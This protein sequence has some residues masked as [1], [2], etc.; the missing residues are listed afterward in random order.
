MGQVSIKTFLNTQQ[1]HGDDEDHHQQQHHSETD[2]QPDMEIQ[3]SV[4]NHD[5]AVIAAER[6]L[7]PSTCH[8][9]VA[10]AVMDW[11]LY[12]RVDPWSMCVLNQLRVRTYTPVMHVMFSSRRILSPRH[13]IRPRQETLHRGACQSLD[14]DTMGELFVTGDDF[15]IVTVGHVESLLQTEKG[16]DECVTLDTALGIG[17][18]SKIAAVRW[19]L[20]NQNE[21][22]VLQNKGRS[23]HLFDINRTQGDPSQ[24]I[25]LASGGESLTYFDQSATM[26]QKYCAAVGCTDGTVALC[27]S[28]SGAQPVVVMRSMT[29]GAIGCIQTMDHGRLV[30]GGTHRDAIKL[31]DLRK[32]SG[33][34]VHF[35]AV[36]NKHPILHTIHLVNEISMIPGLV[37]ESGYIPVCTPQSLHPDP[38]VY[39]RVAVHM[40]CGWTSVLDVSR[41]GMTHFHAPPVADNIPQELEPA[42]SV[43]DAVNARVISD[44]GRVVLPHEIMQLERHDSERRLA[45]RAGK[46]S[47]CWLQGSQFVAPSRSKNA[48]LIIDFG[49][50]SDSATWIGYKEGNS[51]TTSAVSIDVPLEPTCIAP[52]VHD[53]RESLLA[54]GRDGHCTLLQS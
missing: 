40:A 47:G 5:D 52:I 39:S 23:L 33:S 15:G 46:V 10:K 9:D 16:V 7:L 53:G 35:G 51:R 19:N 1:Q 24:T 14:V 17:L 6:G 28:R 49:A 12:G 3:D 27:D 29:G 44:S 42:M 4:D 26:G 48:V 21:V 18:Y 13:M 38:D 36:T 20:S 11:S 41:L 31:W 54:F 8:N 43:E 34:A 30:L 25:K 50:S 45:D 32:V 2:I 22:G 37:D